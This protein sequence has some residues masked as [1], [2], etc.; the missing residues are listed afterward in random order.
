M[1]SNFCIPATPYLHKKLDNKRSLVGARPNHRDLNLDLIHL[2]GLTQTVKEPVL[3]ES[4]PDAFEGLR[5]DWG[6]W[7]FW[8]LQL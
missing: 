7:G 4:G 6:V 5:V 1:Q 3:K 2:T 8:E